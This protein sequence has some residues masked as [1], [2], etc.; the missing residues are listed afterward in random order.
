MG[1]EFNL[2]S[3]TSIS[4]FII[5]VGTFYIVAGILAMIEGHEKHFHQHKERYWPFILFLSLPIG[6]I[7]LGY[8]L[9]ASNLGH[10]V[11][12]MFYKNS[13]YTRNIIITLLIGLAAL[14]ELLRNKKAFNFKGS[15]LVFGA[16]FIFCS[17]YLV[18]HYVAYEGYNPVIH[19]NKNIV[20]LFS[21]TLLTIGILSMLDS[22]YLQKTLLFRIFWSAT[23]TLN[24]LLNLLLYPEKLEAFEFNSQ[25]QSYTLTDL[26]IAFSIALIVVI[27]STCLIHWLCKRKP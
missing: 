4:H 10:I 24:G 21:A 3:L 26:S 13:V 9:G 20:Y 25:H 17:V 23:L 11:L 5:L 19:Y 22:L 8:T 16:T 12:E 6:L 2:S 27:I 14:W 1:N 18:N 15:Q 7:Q